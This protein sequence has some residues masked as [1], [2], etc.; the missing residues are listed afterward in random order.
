MTAEEQET[1]FHRWLRDHTGLMLKVVR[2]CAET[3]HDQEDLFQDVLVN[4]W[5]SIPNFRGDSKETTWIYRVSINTALVW[6]RGERRRQH[7]HAILL[8]EAAAPM[9]SSPDEKRVGNELIERMYA[10]IRQL[11]KVDASLA[12]MHLDGLR[13][14]EMSEV[15]GISE[16]YIG[17]KLTRIRKQLAEQLGHLDD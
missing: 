6:Q 4:L 7:H 12:L 5:S 3:P 17:V 16:N 10:A 15:L 2:A 13:Y 8:N 11:P 9:P 1:H 14:Q